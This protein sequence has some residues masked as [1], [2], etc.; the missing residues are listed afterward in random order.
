MMERHEEFNQITGSFVEE[1]LGSARAPT[2][3]AGGR[4]R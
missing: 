3:S 1:A 2:R 4:R